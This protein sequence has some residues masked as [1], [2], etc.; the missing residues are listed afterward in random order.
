MFNKVISRKN[1]GCFKHDGLKTVYGRDDIVPLWVADMDFAVAPVITDAIARRMQHP[2]YGYNLIQD[3]FYQAAIAWQKNRHD[4]DI[5]KGHIIAVP[6]LMTALAIVV[7]TQTSEDDHILIQ[8]PVYPPFFSS[9]TGHNR[10]LL[11][12]ELKSNSG[13]YE[14]DWED[15]EAKAKLAKMFI[16]CNP[17]N[18]VGR[19]FTVDELS[20]MN[21]ICAK[22]NVIIFSDEIHA[23]IVYAPN[24]HFPI[25]KLGYQ[26]VITGISPAKSFN[27]AGMATAIM[28]TL[29]GEIAAQLN[30]LNRGLHTF[31]GNSFGLAAFTAAFAEG[32]EWLDQLTAYLKGNRDYLGEF[33]ASEL[34]Q[35]KVRD[36]E[37]TYLAW[38]DCSALGLTDEEMSKFFVEKARVALNPGTSFGKEGSGFMRLNFATPRVVLEEGLNRIK[39]SIREIL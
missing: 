1:S 8:T 23:D 34:P 10:K 29:D 21:E 30:E 37:G 22:Y 15:F 26:R 19:V 5:A 14:I 4:F 9:V 36:C 16:L 20:R 33:M 31:M 12:N 32:G 11:T 7:L 35:I 3:D 13:Y 18:P 2:I 17:H 39:N 6:S 28:H 24:Q 25:G 27:L 38:L